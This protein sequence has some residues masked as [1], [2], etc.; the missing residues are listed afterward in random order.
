MKETLWVLLSF[1]FIQILVISTI[2][3]DDNNENAFKNK[4]EIFL[5]YIP[6]SWIILI[7]IKVINKI[8]KY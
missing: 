4:L 8:R 3:L 7:G 5:Y 6:Y 2:I 1:Y